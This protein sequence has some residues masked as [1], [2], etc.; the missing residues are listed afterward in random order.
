MKKSF[1]FIKV[2][3]LALFI[4]SCKTNDDYVNSDRGTTPIKYLQVVPTDNSGNRDTGVPANSPLYSP[5]FAAISGTLYLKS[6]ASIPLQALTN[7]NIQI[8]Q[9]INNKWIH[10]AEVVTNRNGNFSLTQKT[11]KGR[12][13]LNIS[14]PRYLG[15]MLITLHEKPSLNLIFEAE[16]RKNNYENCMTL[17][18]P[19]TPGARSCGGMSAHEF[20]TGGYLIE[21]VFIENSETGKTIKQQMDINVYGFNEK[22]WNNIGVFQSSVEGEFRIAI[23]DKYL[24]VKLV[25][26]NAKYQTE[27]VFLFGKD[28]MKHIKMKLHVKSKE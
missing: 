2:V 4:Q 10:F 27:Q 20:L 9:N 21:G 24:Q 26:E 22:K 6:D 3:L 5:Y 18:P 7:V 23:P 14:D 28:D 1:I 13:R 17:V 11:P 25:I 16:L 8:D 19:Q 15:E 12:Y